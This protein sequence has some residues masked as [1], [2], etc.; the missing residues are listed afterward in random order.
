MLGLEQKH[1]YACLIDDDTEHKKAKGTKK[2]IIKREFMF[3]NYEDC[4]FNDKIVLKSQQIFKSNHRSVYIYT[5][6]K[7]IKF[8]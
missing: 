7:S 4:F 3:K 1:I 8:H 6:N 5:L 2:C